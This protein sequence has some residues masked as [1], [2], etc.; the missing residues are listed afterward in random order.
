[1]TALE[2]A[3]GNALPTDVSYGAKEVL[4]KMSSML[5]GHNV[6]APHRDKGAP[7]PLSSAR[8][9]KGGAIVEVAES[10]SI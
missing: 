10:T 6:Y 2:L 3:R 4:T 9:V 1:M 5:K 7:G 8:E